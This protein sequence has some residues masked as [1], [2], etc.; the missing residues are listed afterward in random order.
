MGNRELIKIAIENDLF[1][2]LKKSA[3]QVDLNAMLQTGEITYYGKKY[4]INK[5]VTNA[6]SLDEFLSNYTDLFSYTRTGVKGKSTDKKSITNKLRRFQLETGMSYEEILELTK[7][8]TANYKQ[9]SG[10]LVMAKYFF[11]KQNRFK[12]EETSWAKSI[13]EEWRAQEEQIKLFETNE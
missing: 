4:Y 13:I 6:M 7:Y 11:Y 10:F 8:Y 12:S 2:L 1:H 9:I 3:C 5:E